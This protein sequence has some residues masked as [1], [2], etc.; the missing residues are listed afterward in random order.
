MPT[1]GWGNIYC[2]SF[3]GDTALASGGGGGFDPDYQAVLDYATTQGYSLPS[4]GQQTLQN[5]LVTDLKAAGYWNRYDAFAMMATDGDSNFS[6]ID[7]KRLITMTAVN[8][9][10][11]TTNVGYR[12]GAASAYI[13]T[14]YAPSTDGVNYTQNNAGVSILQNQLES[15]ASGRYQ[16]GTSSSSSGNVRFRS[17]PNPDTMINGGIITGGG[18]AFNVLGHLHN[19]RLN[20][21]QMQL[22]RD[23]VLGP[24]LADNSTGLPSGNIWLFRIITIYSDAGLGYFIAR[25]AMTEAEKNNQNSIIDTYLNAI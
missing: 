6:L 15:A 22:Q 20:A 18:V 10:T 25:D 13:D 17:S 2:N 19:D 14:L 9:P 23:D 8:S 3:S 1:N 21:T 11:F 24:I 5:T 16:L 7:W 12:G 4:A